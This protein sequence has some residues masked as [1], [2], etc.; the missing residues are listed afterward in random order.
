M[1]RFL[2]CVHDATPVYEAETRLM[3][4]DLSRLVGRRLSFAVVPDWNGEFPL[5][6]HPEFCH[7]VQG[8]SDEL[9][10][11]G[12]FHKRRRGWS[13]TTFLAE[14][15]DEM[16]GLDAEHTRRMMERGQVVFTEVFG[17]PARGFVAPAWQRG[18]VRLQGQSAPA[19]EHVLGFFS[20]EARDGRRVPLATFTWDCGRWRW[21][22]YIGH[23]A[24]CLLHLGGRVPVL[25]IHPRDLLRGFWPTILRLTHSLLDAGYV[26][27]TAAGLLR[28]SEC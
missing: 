16:S 24:A 12:Y 27:T 25:A 15:S 26:P 3:I 22:G 4:R 6:M 10:L 2:L 23:G 17:A 21:L 9:L 1:R 8:S 7:L 20:L 5:A 13:P 14:A 19:L 28:A 18:H 11:H